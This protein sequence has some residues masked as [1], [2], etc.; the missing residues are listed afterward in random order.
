VGELAASGIA[1]KLPHLN[2]ISIHT[3]IP[4]R[5]FAADNLR[6]WYSPS[7]RRCREDIPISISA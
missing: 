4:S 2:A 1:I 6:V 3:A 7:S 5:R